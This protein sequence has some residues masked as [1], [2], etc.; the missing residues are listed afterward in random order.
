[1]LHTLQGCHI[2]RLLA[3]GHMPLGCA[4]LATQLVVGV[5]LSSLHTIPPAVCVAAEAVLGVVHALGVALGD[6]RLQ[7]F[8]LDTAS[9]QGSADMSAAAT[10]AGGSGAS[11]GRS[12]PGASR[13]G[14]GAGVSVAM[15]QPPRVVL[16]DFGR[17]YMHAPPAV[18]SMERSQ[19]LALLRMH[20]VNH[21][22]GAGPGGEA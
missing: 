20:M 11:G 16:V 22:A 1:M 4:F 14:V 5:P 6:V 13:V 8:L 12:G 17:A 9:V 15:A 2:P 7:N 18:L 19:L 21:P 10:A 3:V